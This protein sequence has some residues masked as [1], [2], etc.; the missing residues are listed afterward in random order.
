[1]DTLVQ[2]LPQMHGL[3]MLVIHPTDNGIIEWHEEWLPAFQANLSLVALRQGTSLRPLFEQPLTALGSIFQRNLL[4]FRARKF[5]SEFARDFAQETSRKEKEQELVHL[6]A[7]ISGTNK[8]T[9]ASALFHL[10]R[11]S[12]AMCLTTRSPVPHQPRT[13]K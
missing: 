12:V 13:S 2:A 4:L 7:D 5:S 9:S 6:M 11:E 1:M 8:D 3:R 10:V